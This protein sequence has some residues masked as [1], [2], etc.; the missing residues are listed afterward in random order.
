MEYQEE[1]TEKK[2]E[3]TQINEKMDES[4]VSLKKII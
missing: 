4:H 3:T 2:S 1:N